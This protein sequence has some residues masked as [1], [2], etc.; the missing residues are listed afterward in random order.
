MYLSDG[1][2]KKKASS[3]LKLVVLSEELRL[4]I[5]SKKWQDIG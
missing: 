3:D 5:V 4:G 2:E 1:E